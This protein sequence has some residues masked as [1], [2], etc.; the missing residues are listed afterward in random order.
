MF[1]YKYEDNNGNREIIECEDKND[2]D[3]VMKEIYEN[4]CAAYEDAD[5]TWLNE[6][7]T[8]EIY[9]PDTS[10]FF[11]F[12]ILDTDEFHPVSAEAVYTGG[13]IWVFYGEASDGNWFLTDDYGYTLILNINPDTDWDECF[14]EDW[15]KEHLIKELEGKERTDFADELADLLH[16]TDCV[17]SDDEIEGYR[18]YWKEEF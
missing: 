16:K 11:R 17:I 13:N 2:I 8:S 12:T 7:K 3:T 5:V 18:E 9:V 15:Q 4:M 14:Y 6:N 10:I 1:K